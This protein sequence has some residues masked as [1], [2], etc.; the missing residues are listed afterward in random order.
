MSTSS[1]DV[2]LD[3]AGAGRPS[4]DQLNAIFDDMRRW[5]LANPHS[6]HQSSRFTSDL[7]EKSR[8]R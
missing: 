1:I 8:L 6:N 5:Q 4:T 7:I 3:H 2:Y